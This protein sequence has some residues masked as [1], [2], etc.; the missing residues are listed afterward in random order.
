MGGAQAGEVASEIAVDAFDDGLPATARRP[1]G[2]AE[3]IAARPTARI[4]DALALRRSSAPGMGTTCTAAYV[5][6]DEVVIAHVGDS[7]AYLLRD[8]ELTRLTRDHSLVGELVAPRQAHRGAGR[9]R[10]RSAR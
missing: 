8:G 2:S 3:S 7:R 6:D 1:S 4:H 10:T 5:G 9:A